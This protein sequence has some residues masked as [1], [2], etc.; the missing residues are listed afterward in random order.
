MDKHENIIFYEPSGVGKTTLKTDIVI[1]QQQRGVV[2][3]L[4]N[5]II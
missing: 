3:I 2:L 4:L 5:A 1:Q